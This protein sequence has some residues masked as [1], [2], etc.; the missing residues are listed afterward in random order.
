MIS[1]HLLPILLSAVLIWAGGLN[2]AGPD[3]IREEFAKWG[4]SDG[5]RMS[6]GLAEWAAAIALIVVPFRMLG[7]ALAAI[8]LLGVI[9][10]FARDRSLM[11]LEYPLVLLAIDMMIAVQTLGLIS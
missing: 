11:R 1:S 8:I 9:V 4:Y 5:L 10:T 7:C 3:F 2:L 6:V